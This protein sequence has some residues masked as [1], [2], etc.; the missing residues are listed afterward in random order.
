MSARVEAETY[1]P[2]R[3]VAAEP[4]RSDRTLFAIMALA[5]LALAGTIALLPS[6]EEKAQGLLA[7]GRYGDAIE[8]LVGVED[9]RPINA[10]ERY[11]L[12]KL[13]MLTRQPQSAAMLLEQASG[14]QVDKVWALRQVS[15]LYRQMR[16]PVG[17]AAILRQLYD[18]NPAETEFARLRALYRLLGDSSGEASL[19]A[20]AIAAG[21][22]APVHLDR[23][24]YLRSQPAAGGLAAVWVAPSSSFLG[25]GASPSFQ[26]LAS[27]D[28][29]RSSTS[30][31]D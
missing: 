18:L 31:F 22:A 27:S 21:E 1:R 5:L 13:Y 30:P 8:M 7:E 17:E 2:A 24:A 10:Y 6:T 12:F 26:V 23:L 28:L 11:M 15:D 20:Q 29:E 19:L 9:E 25:F 3:R 14:L 16:D 4:A